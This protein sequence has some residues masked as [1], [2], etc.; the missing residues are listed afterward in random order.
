MD[1]VTSDDLLESDADRPDI[2]QELVDSLGGNVQWHSRTDIE[3]RDEALHVHLKPPL[4]RKIRLYLYNI[5]PSGRDDE[6]KLNARLPTIEAGPNDGEGDDGDVDY[7]P[8][9]SDD[10]LV[11]V[12]GY[13]EQ[14]EIWAF[15]DDS[16]KDTYSENPPLQIKKKTVEKAASDGFAVQERDRAGDGGETVVAVER[17]AVDEGIDFRARFTRNRRIL[18]EYLHQGWRNS[19][20][21]AQVVERI[22]DIVL[23]DTDPDRPMSE[24]RKEAVR[25]VANER[26]INT[27]SVKRKLKGGLFP[28]ELP[29]KNGYIATQFDPLL[30]KVEDAV[31]TEREV[32]ENDLL[33]YIDSLSTET[34]IQ[35]VSLPPE[36]WIV[37][38]YYN[39]IPFADEGDTIPEGD[40]ILFHLNDDSDVLNSDNYETGLIGG[41][42]AGTTRQK[43]EHE[44]RWYQ[45]FEDNEDYP[46]Y[47]EFCRVFYC[48]KVGDLDLK[49]TIGEKDLSDIE[50]ETYYLTENLF[51]EERAN[52]I[53]GIDFSPTQK[54]LEIERG[55]EPSDLEPA[56]ELVKQ[57]VKR[58]SEAPSV[59]IFAN[60]KG[61][62]DD[63]MF[64]GLHLPGQKKD[65]KAQVNS[66]LRTGKHIIFTGPPGTGKTKIASNVAKM[67]EEQHPWQFSGSQ[68]T[69]ATSD[70]STFDT[71]G[72]YMPEE[73][74]E[75]GDQLSFTSGIL[76]NRLKNDQTLEQRNEPIVIDELNRSN[77][78]EAFGQ[79]F[80]VLSGESIQ[81]QY[82]RDG[83]ELEIATAESVNGLPGDNQY[84]VPESWRI[85]A[86]MN[87]FDKN[88]LYEMSYAF[89]RRFSFISVNDPFQEGSY[90][91][92]DDLNELMRDYEQHWGTDS[93]KQQRIEVATV[94]KYTNEAIDSRA[95]GPAIVKDML[96][97]VVEMTSDS[98]DIEQALTSVVLNYIFPQ[99]EGVRGRETVIKSI[100]ENS[101]VDEGKI[102]KAAKDRL[103]IEFDE[104]DD[105]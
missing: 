17:G 67:L 58:I 94:W 6:Y 4:P 75:G 50:E 35:V 16:L 22:T 71:L 29:G 66:A 88:S 33:R 40:I 86:T 42:I 37:C 91:T 32:I 61:K 27:N 97:G 31:K 78:D 82:K 14:H 23:E 51:D 81:L 12:G 15:W 30:R 69:T 56:R 21:R 7:A 20:S 26:D 39:S 83:E 46:Y 70:W 18:N 2:A 55:D 102:R 54:V 98:L 65:I 80:T 3:G 60:Y 62:L 63:D 34:S 1:L 59:N 104:E 53:V 44:D 19:G 57:L 8:D 49:T 103:K 77:I 38:C 64:E 84:V 41:A 10:Y 92:N 48:G 93:T 72:G 13:H 95:I 28:E 73:D 9:R 24:R 87:T 5:P 90:E 45:E 101:S 36:E 79:L 99:F 11:L 68:I 43:D 47:T 52:E 74:T 96:D 89:M 100:I 25:R 76:L 85:L 105:G